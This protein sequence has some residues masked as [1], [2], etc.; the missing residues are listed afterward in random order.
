MKT[1]YKRIGNKTPI[2]NILLKLIPTHKIYIEPFFGSGA[3][4]FGKE[5]SETEIVNDLDKS[6]M[7]DYKLITKVNSNPDLYI[8]T[9]NSLRKNA[10]KMNEFVNSH[11]ENKEMYFL[12][13]IY[14]RN[15][16]FGGLRSGKIYN[17]DTTHIKKILQLKDYQDRFKGV[18]MLNQ[19][20]K[21]V[22]KKWD[23][24]NSFFF[25]D[26]PYERTRK[27]HFYKGC[28]DFDY[29]ELAEILKKLKGKFLLTLNDSPNIRTI[30]KD[31]NIKTITVVG[32][33]KGEKRIG[34]GIR[35]ELIISNY[36]ILDF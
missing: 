32:K 11:P 23:S 27:N 1:F 8:P 2:L 10:E 5:R 25:L 29:N 22:V 16:G 14:L 28:S 26:P 6:L 18:K 33:G 31:F 35:D 21:T 36:N 13:E 17:H 9:I 15:N 3:L 19:D 12:Q 20:Y 4:F 24:E 7:D 30:F 34:W